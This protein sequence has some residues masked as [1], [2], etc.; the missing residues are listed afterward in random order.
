MRPPLG[1][2]LRSRRTLSMDLSRL[3]IL[4]Q[5][6]VEASEFAPVWD[7]FMTHF[8]EQRGFM[9]LGKGVRSPVLEAAI[10]QAV[11]Q[12]FGEAAPLSNLFLIRL[13]EQQ[14]IHGGLNVKGRFGNV[15]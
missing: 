13:A 9:N 11:E 6:L 3:T 14:F 4:K 1:A 8:G 10:T 15:F 5:K 12:V 2:S 7:Y